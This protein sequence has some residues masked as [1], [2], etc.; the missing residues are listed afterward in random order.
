MFKH[1]RFFL[2]LSIVL[3]AA[4]VFCNTA[5]GD[6]EE[7]PAKCNWKRVTNDVKNIDFYTPSDDTSPYKNI[8]G[9]RVKNVIFLI[10]DG[11]GAGQVAA[12][13]LRAV[14]FAG[15][16]Y[17][18]RMPVVGLIDT[19]AANSIVTDSAAAGTA[20]ACGV[21]T[22]NG[23]VGMTP[24]KTSWE[25]ILE[26]A[27]EKEMRTGLV[28]TSTITHATPASFGSHV[29]SRDMQ[30]KIAEHLLANKVNVMFGGGKAFWNRQST[31]DS[32]R[33]DDIDLLSRAENQGYA[34]VDDNRGLATVEGPYVLGLFQQKA[35][36]TIS[37]EP[38]LAEMTYHAIR[39]LNKK[40]KG[41]FEPDRGF[42]LMVEGSQIDWACHAHDVHD[43]IKQTLL[44]DEA[45][46]V[47]VEFAMSDKN[48]LI[49]ITADH[50]TGGLVV[51]GDDVNNTD[52]INWA[53]G[54]HSA[55]PVPVYAYGPDSKIFSGVYDNTDIPQKIAR[56]L[57][58]KPFPRKLEK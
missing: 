43:C 37:P 6:S 31:Q 25:S 34:T 56:L 20:L 10:G 46:K 36:T 35:L 13:R 8:A 41:L 47:A 48:T 9:H 11:M 53:T 39:L 21:K 4:V 27:G 57:K 58:I 18:E 28:A 55:M 52:H 23:M 42:F 51:K 29:E 54:G 19:H 7:K 12:A 17:I 32:L 45:V 1:E 33:K 50:E 30:G 38:T 15:K 26:A 2:V 40:P 22:N 49:I 24:D 14:G 3:I 16:L 44:F 5:K